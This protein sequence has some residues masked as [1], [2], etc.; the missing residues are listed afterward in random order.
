[1]SDLSE[2]HVVLS[3][4]AGIRRHH[5]MNKQW[6]RA[7]LFSWLVTIHLRNWHSTLISFKRSCFEPKMG[8]YAI[9]IFGSNTQALS[10][11]NTEALEVWPH[12]VWLGAIYAFF[13]YSVSVWFWSRIHEVV[14][15]CDTLN[16]LFDLNSVVFWI[17]HV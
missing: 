17:I 13:F 7:N 5:C 1:M 3:P 9:T 15:R 4:L 8:H 6:V 11:L 14:V 12:H 16:F 10:D 2:I